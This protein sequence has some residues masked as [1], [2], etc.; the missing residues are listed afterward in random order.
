MI[1]LS[2]S[3]E[4]FPRFTSGRREFIHR[5]LQLLPHRDKPAKHY[6]INMEINHKV[7][8]DFSSYFLFM[9]KKSK[10]SYHTKTQEAKKLSEIRKR[11]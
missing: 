5:N 3:S 6:Q 10:R 8:P 7:E 1:K 4:K 2:S 9:T 11:W